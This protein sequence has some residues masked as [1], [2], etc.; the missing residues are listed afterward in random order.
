MIFAALLLASTTVHVIDGDTV[1]LGEETVRIAN[2]DAPEIHQAKCDAERRLGKIAKARLETLLL[3]GE[4][5]MRRGDP[6]SHRMKDRHGRTL[7]TVSVDGRD[8]G[9]TLIGEQLAR[10]WRGKRQPWCDRQP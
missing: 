3:S 7:G 4:I 6:A 1:R 9:V 2:I 5:A 8:V 10:P